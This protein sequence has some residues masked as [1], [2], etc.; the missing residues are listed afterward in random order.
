[1]KYDARREGNEW[2]PY[3][4]QG[5]HKSSQRDAAPRITEQHAGMLLSLD[6]EKGRLILNL[7]HSRFDGSL[8]SLS[9]VRFR[10]IGHQVQSLGLFWRRKITGNWIN[11]LEIVSQ[12]S[13]VVAGVLREQFRNDKLKINAQFHYAKRDYS[14][15]HA[16]PYVP[17][18]TSIPGTYGILVGLEHRGKGIKYGGWMAHLVRLHYRDNPSETVSGMRFYLLKSLSGRTTFKVYYSIRKKDGE[19][20]V[21]T[22]AI[23]RFRLGMVIPEQQSETRFLQSL[24]STG[25]LSATMRLSRGYGNGINA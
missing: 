12:E 1:M 8:S 7:W 17:F 18:T 11:E 15:L 25:V 2:L 23:H 22:P 6:G 24:L 19:T 10:N 9:P 4:E 5:N 3:A 20:G 16:R 21:G 14:T 13:G